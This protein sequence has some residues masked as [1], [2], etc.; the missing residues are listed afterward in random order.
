MKLRRQLKKETDKNTK[1]NEIIKELEVAKEGLMNE[2]T[3]LTGNT[4]DFMDEFGNKSESNAKEG[5]SDVVT[6]DNRARRMKD[7]EELAL[8]VCD[9]Y[10]IC[11]ICIYIFHLF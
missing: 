6:D 1:S 10:L 3:R 4:D 2:I 5:Y 11:R 9:F 7:E 8:L